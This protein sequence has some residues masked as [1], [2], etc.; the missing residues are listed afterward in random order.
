MEFYLSTFISGFQKLIKKILKQSIKDAKI[1]LLLDGAVV[2]KTNSSIDKLKQ[3]KFFNNTFLI[4][5]QFPNLKT[6]KPFDYM[7]KSIS[8]LEDLGKRI[9][10]F[11]NNSNRFFRIMTSDENRFI[12]SDKNLLRKIE[13]KI[14]SIKKS[15]LKF[16]LYKTDTEFW[17]LKRREN[18]G[19]FLLRLTKNKSKLEKGELRPELAYI[20]CYLSEPNKNDIF[21][22]PFAGHGAIPIK[23][24]KYF[25]SNMIFA[26]DKIAGYKKYINKKINSRAIRE[27]IIPKVLDAT[28]MDFFQDN[29]VTKI[30]TDPPWGEYE[31]IKNIKEFYKKILIE[32]ERILIKK[33]IL[34][35]LT[36]KKQEFENV[37][38]NISNFTI[39]EK[40]DI[41]VSGQKAGVYKI[42]KN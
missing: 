38:S 27:R 14:M 37:L 7:M 13:E 19:F 35:L 36:S 5:K 26:S 12:S 41:L 17:F 1:S 42:I 6:K 39:K 28:K 33:G 8:N 20:L 15:K 21:L 4:I 25:A 29:Y 32:F 16:S 30:V 31:E 34:V 2:Y 10:P 23:R 9:K 24:A 11:L 22:D 3:L 18:I 40:Y